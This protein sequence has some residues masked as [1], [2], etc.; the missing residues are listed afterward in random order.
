MGLLKPFGIAKIM[1]LESCSKTITTLDFQSEEYSPTRTEIHLFST[2]N[3][4]IEK[5]FAIITL[6]RLG[7]Y[8]AE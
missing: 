7:Q 2:V 8:N 5:A 3:M 4:E 1:Q 6:A